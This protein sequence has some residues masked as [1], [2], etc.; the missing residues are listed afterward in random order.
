MTY[1][2]EEIKRPVLKRVMVKGAVVFEYDSEKEDFF[3]NSTIYLAQTALILPGPS[4]EIYSIYK[5]Y[6]SHLIPLPR[7]DVRCVFMMHC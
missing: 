4:P 2:V 7:P 6:T 5:K 1:K 3:M